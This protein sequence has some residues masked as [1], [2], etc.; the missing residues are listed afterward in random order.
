MKRQ[1][2]SGT[3]K[4]DPQAP[5]GLEGVPPVVLQCLGSLGKHHSILIK[6]T[7][8]W[9]EQIYVVGV[10]EEQHGEIF[11]QSCNRQIQVLG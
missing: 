8:Q 7:K 5:E 1:L 4:C 10:G 9:Y 3:G 11:L 6:R 2:R